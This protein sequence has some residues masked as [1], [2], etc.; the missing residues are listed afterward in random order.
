M[1]LSCFIEE[2]FLEI[3]GDVYEIHDENK[4]CR[5]FNECT[6][7]YY[8]LIFVAW[9][10]NAMNKSWLLLQSYLRQT[11]N[12]FVFTFIKHLFKLR[13]ALHIE[14]F[15]EKV[16]NHIVL[17]WTIRFNVMQVKQKPLKI[18]IT[19]KVVGFLDFYI[20]PG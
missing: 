5:Y 13:F 20:F 14:C 18:C 3:H 2:F 11:F 19:W 7:S 6:F 9:K 4:E 12:F 15:V 17:I 16:I 8:G 10:Y 1:F